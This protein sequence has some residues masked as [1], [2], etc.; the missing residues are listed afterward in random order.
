[1]IGWHVARDWKMHTR[2]CHL[3]TIGDRFSSFSGLESVRVRVSVRSSASE[4]YMADCRQAIPV[5]V[6]AGCRQAIQN[7]YFKTGWGPRSDT[8]RKQLG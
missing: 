6:A 3:I 7:V 1:M 4:S 5:N 8:H 2:L